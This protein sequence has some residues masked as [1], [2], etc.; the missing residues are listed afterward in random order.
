MQDK[1]PI[2]SSREKLRR[3]TSTLEA[4]LDAVTD[5]I[6]VVDG[7]LSAV[8]MNKRFRE[9]WKVDPT[10]SMTQHNILKHAM[11]QV[12]DKDQFR[13]MVV[14]AGAHPCETMTDEIRL[15]DGRLLE[16]VSAP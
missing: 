4:V 8:R 3:S 5:A 7:G 13:A 11:S 16:R 9:M 14:Y 10:E 6:L 12:V 1:T 2:S 15:T